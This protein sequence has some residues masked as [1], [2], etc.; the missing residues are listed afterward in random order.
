MTLTVV[1][2][3]E[4]GLFCK[5]QKYLLPRRIRKKTIGYSSMTNAFLKFINIFDILF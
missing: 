1:Y 5:K 3:V 4:N 2:I